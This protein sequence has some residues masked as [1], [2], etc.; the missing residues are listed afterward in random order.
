MIFE[1][2]DLFVSLVEVGGV[3][4]VGDRRIGGVGLWT[5]R[6][7]DVFGEATFDFVCLAIILKHK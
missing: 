6:F 1:E 3:Q 7:A 5:K 2:V 4:V